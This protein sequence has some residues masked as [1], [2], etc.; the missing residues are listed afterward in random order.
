MKL[1]RGKRTLVAAVGMLVAATVLAELLLRTIAGLGDPPLYRTDPDVE[2]IL[3]PGTYRRFGNTVFVNSAHMRSPEAALGPRREGERRVMVLGDSVVN[4]GSLTDQDS[5]ATQM[6]PAMALEL[7]F[8]APVTVCNVS[9]GSWGPGNLLAFVQRFGTFDCTDAVIVLNS[10]DAVDV[11][12]FA[13]LGPEQPTDPPLLALQEL[14]QNYGARLFRRNTASPAHPVASGPAADALGDLF[15]FL[16][17]RGVRCRLLFHPTR[18]QLD[19]GQDGGVGSL[20]AQAASRGVPRC[21]T[22][23]RLL[24]MRAGGLEPYRDDIHPAAVGQ[25]ALAKAIL[26]CLGTGR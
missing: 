5:L 16:T 18:Q 26:D 3:V 19:Q 11:P 6:L 22:A 24:E 1:T 14:V 21:S 10:E 4:G 20:D 2:Y 7:D 15:D 23:D 17:S 9:A 8:S 13:A 25:K 12:T